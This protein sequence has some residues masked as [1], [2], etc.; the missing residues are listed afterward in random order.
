MHRF[1]LCAVLQQACHIELAIK[2][3]GID[4]LTTRHKQLKKTLDYHIHAYSRRS[5]I[6]KQSSSDLL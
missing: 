4:E 2:R 3:Y 6:S 1:M 5:L